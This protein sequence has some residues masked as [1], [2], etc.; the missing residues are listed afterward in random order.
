MTKERQQRIERPPVA[1][2]RQR[3]GSGGR[4]LHVRTAEQRHQR[5]DRPPIAQP[6][7]NQRGREPRLAIV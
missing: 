2:A 6:A 5:L 3:G 1:E 4:Q 7:E